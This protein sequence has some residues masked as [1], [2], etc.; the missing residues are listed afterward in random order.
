MVDILVNSDN[1]YIF[2]IHFY[3]L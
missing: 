3:N 2:V 1:G